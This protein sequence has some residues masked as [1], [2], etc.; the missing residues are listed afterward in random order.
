MIATIAKRITC[1]VL[2]GALASSGDAAGRAAL[3]ARVWPAVAFAP[4]TVRIEVLIETDGDNRAL[5]IVADS[6]EHLRSSTIQLDGVRAARFYSVVYRGM[7]AGH[8]EVQVELL[9]PRDT[10]RAIERHWIDL[11]G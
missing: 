3:Q 4:A 2:L 7:P 8:Y 5:R 1:A 9:D 10:V 11:V 6:G